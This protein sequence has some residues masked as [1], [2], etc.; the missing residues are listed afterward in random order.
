MDIE[1]KVILFDKFKINV[2]LLKQIKPVPKLIF[3]SKLVL[4][5][6]VLRKF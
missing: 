3:T 1:I 5:F 6:I 2:T 4:Y